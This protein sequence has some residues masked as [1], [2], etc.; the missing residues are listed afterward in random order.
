MAEFNG[1]T[2]LIGNLLHLVNTE[3][4]ITVP[5]KKLIDAVTQPVKD[6]AQ[7]AMVVEP[8]QHS[9]ASTFAIR[10]KSVQFLQDINFKLRQ[11]IIIRYLTYNFHHTAFTISF[12]ISAVN[13]LSK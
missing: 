5:L 6:N 3:R 4:S 8:V 10:I 9:D 13:N 11:V 7:M 12:K 2:Q 1:F